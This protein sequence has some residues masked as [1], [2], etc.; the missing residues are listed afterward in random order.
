MFKVLIV[1]VGK[2]S[3]GVE[4]YTLILGKMLTNSGVDVHY[5]VRQGA[6][7]DKQLTRE[8]KIVVSMGKNILTDMRHLKAYVEEQKINIVQCNSNNGLLV[9][10]FIKETASCKK[11]GVIH[12]DVKVDQAHK[13]VLATYIYEKIETHLIKK[14]CT[15]CIAVSESI[16]SILI[17]RGVPE[18]KIDVIYTGIVP[19]EYTESPDYDAKQLKIVTVGNL[20][21]VK[22]QIA[23]LKAL[24]V[25]KK[26]KPQFDFSCDIYGEGVERNHLEQ[27][28]AENELSNV[29]LKG[30]DK[31]VRGKLNKYQLYVHTSKYESFGI[32][33]VEAMDA[34]CCV[35]TSDVG[36]IS[37][38]VDNDC[39]IFINPDDTADFAEKIYQCGTDRNLLK[40]YANRGRE[41]C[42]KEFYCTA[43]VENIMNIYR[44]LI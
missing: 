3:G 1:S 17:G 14:A 27:Y 35:L 34:G 6:W 32:S 11:I 30:F 8:K 37:E 42:Q 29:S 41:R 5:A 36:G 2:M 13:G 31:D 4:S 28:I 40:S 23:I 44:K 33:V 12:G 19:M 25:L 22:N 18:D 9:S 16:K 10:G 38:I 15:R 7:L 39:G 26:K 21:P 24:S 20:L 43:M